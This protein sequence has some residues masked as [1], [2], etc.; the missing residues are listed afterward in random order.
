VRAL[1][2][3]LLALAVAAPAA[4]AAPPARMLVTADEWMLISSRQSVKAGRVQVQL[5]NRGEDVHDIAARRVDRLGRRV[6]RTWRIGETRPGELGEATWRL[7]SGKYRLWCTLRSHEA[8]GM[9]ARLR[10]R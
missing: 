6:G 2:G 3:A 9:R 5:Y 7:R 8:A 4:G 1:L 10:A